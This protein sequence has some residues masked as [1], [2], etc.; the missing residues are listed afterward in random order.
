MPVIA[1]SIP[2]LAGKTEAFRSAH[3]FAAETPIRSRRRGGGP[4]MGSGTGGASLWWRNT[5][6][7][8]N[9]ARLREEKAPM[10]SA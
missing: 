10:Q 4:R 5:H 2:I 7:P 6:F 9:F 3:L 1:F 8:R